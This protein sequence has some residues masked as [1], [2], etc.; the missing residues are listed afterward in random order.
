MTNENEVYSSS[1]N[2]ADT[3][4]KTKVHYEYQKLHCTHLI[5]LVIIY[6]GRE[7]GGSGEGVRTS[8]GVTPPEEVLS[9]HD[10][11]TRNSYLEE[12]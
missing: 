5:L 6:G 10:L 3:T 7:D 9:Q 12:L 1:S 8:G 2:A 11:A 4:R